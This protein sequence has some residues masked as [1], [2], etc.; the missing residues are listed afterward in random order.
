M[1]FGIDT[2]IVVLAFGLVTVTAALPRKNRIPAIARFWQQSRCVHL[3]SSARRRRRGTTKS[4]SRCEPRFTR[5]SQ[6][7]A[8]SAKKDTSSVMINRVTRSTRQAA[9]NP[10]GVPGEMNISR[11]THDLVQEFFEITPRGAIAAKNKG[12][13]EMFFVEGIKPKWRAPDEDTQPGFEFRKMLKDLVQSTAP[14]DSSIHILQ[15]SGTPR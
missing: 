15:D 2:K 9:W 3:W 10:Q 13:L 7:P 4:A 12:E 8:S 11:A 14:Q 5:A 6:R 1:N